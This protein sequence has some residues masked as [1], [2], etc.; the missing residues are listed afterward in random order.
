MKAK[1]VVKRITAAGG[2]LTRQVGSHA[3]YTITVNGITCTTTV[4]MHSARDIPL[5][6]LRAI[7]KD[8]APALG[9]RWL[10]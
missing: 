5:G 9:E 4:A 3:R 1:E 7:E 8:L 2:S 6:T 10:R